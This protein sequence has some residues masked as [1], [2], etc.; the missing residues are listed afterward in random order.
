MNLQIKKTLALNG[1]VQVPSSKSHS[2][3]GL[4]M[5]LLC[6]GQT[7]LQNVLIAEDTKDAMQVCQALGGKIKIFLHLICM[8]SLYLHSI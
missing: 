1:Q 8:T 6:K 7:R 5:A 3:R 2:I 4:I